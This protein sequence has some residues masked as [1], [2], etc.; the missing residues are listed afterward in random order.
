V[1]IRWFI[2]LSGSG[3]FCTT[4]FKKGE[5]LLEYA[6]DYISHKEALDREKTYAEQEKGSFIF[7]FKFRDQMK[8]WVYF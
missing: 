6:G 3:V 1:T 2:F 7:F 8:W 4:D 5:F